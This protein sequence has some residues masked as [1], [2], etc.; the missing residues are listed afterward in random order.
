MENII[1]NG[2]FQELSDEQLVCLEGGGFITAFVVT[3]ASGVVFMAGVA[4]GYVD[5]RDRLTGPSTSG[6][7]NNKFA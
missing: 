7:N 4:T 1:S 5:R 6:S 3:V 2:M